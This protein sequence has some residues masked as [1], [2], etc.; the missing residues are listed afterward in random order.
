MF[1]V[2][3]FPTATTAAVQPIFD[4][5]P[6]VN[7][8]D[9]ETLIDQ[10]QRAAESWIDKRKREDREAVH[11]WLE[12]NGYGQYYKLFIEHEV[13]QMFIVKGIGDLELQHFGITDIQDRMG[14]LAA[15]RDL[16]N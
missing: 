6:A 15:I 3:I 10:E 16:G 7:P 11:E 2:D 12:I 8:V 1:C 13:V 4:P 5:V 14:L 9:L